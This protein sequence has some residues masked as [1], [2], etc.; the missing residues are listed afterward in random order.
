MGVSSDNVIRL[1]TRA[2]N[3]PGEELGVGTVAVVVCS[4]SEKEIVLGKPVVQFV[5]GGIAVGQHRSQHLVVEDLTGLILVRE[6]L[7]NIDCL[8]RDAI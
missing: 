7:Q 4:A 5:N 2:P 8:R 6:V 1:Q 3:K